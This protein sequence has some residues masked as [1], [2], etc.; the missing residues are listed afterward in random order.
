MLGR[1]DPV[2]IS[3]AD[4]VQEKAS[5]IHRRPYE[6]SKV[7]MYYHSFQPFGHPLFHP[8]PVAIVLPSSDQVSLKHGWWLPASSVACTPASCHTPPVPGAPAA[9]TFNVLA[10][11]PGRLS[12]T[13]P[14][15]NV[16]RYSRMPPSLPFPALLS[17]IICCRCRRSSLRQ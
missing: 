9:R 1:E 5:Q 16:P 6:C 2:S 13:R 15:Q 8:C 11:W 3:E 10:C 4:Q 12:R 17:N 7:P 14:N